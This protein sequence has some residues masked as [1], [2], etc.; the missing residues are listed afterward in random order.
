LDC[1]RESDQRSGKEVHVWTVDDRKSTGSFID[2]GVDNLITNDPAALRALIDERANLP[3]WRSCTRHLSPTRKRRL[4]MLLFP[5]N[6]V[7]QKV[8]PEAKRAAGG[9]R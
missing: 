5:W 4:I 7:I 8:I 6:R 2:L 3:I 1:E 9:I